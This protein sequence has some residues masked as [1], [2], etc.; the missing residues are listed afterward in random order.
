M[1]RM[2]E[3]ATLKAMEVANRLK[4]Q[5]VDIIAFNVG[6]PD[7]D[8]PTHIRRAAQKALDEGYTH[9]TP[10]AG[11]M[12]LREAVADKCKQ[13]NGIPCEAGNVI[14]TTCK[15][16]LFATILSMIEHGDEVIIPEPSWGSYVDMVNLAGGKAVHIGLK[17]DDKFRLRP[18]AV[19]EVITPKTKLIF[20]NSPTNPTGGIIQGKDMKAITELAED[21][22]LCILSDE[23]YEY[24][25]HEGKHV[26]PAS[27]PGIF[28]R[29]V[30][31]NGFSKAFSMTGW[32]MGY[33]VAPKEML[34]VIIK[35]Q[36]QAVT[37]APAFSQRACLTALRS[38]QS[39]K[40]LARMVKEFKKRRDVVVPGLDKIP[41]IKCPK[42]PGTFYAFP[43]F[44]RKMYDLTAAE[45]ATYLLETGHVSVT[46]GTAFGPSGEGCFRLSYSNSLKNIREGLKR[47][48]DALAKLRA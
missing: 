9:Y 32:R 38:K 11:F 16:A 1:G 31:V 27:F 33:L 3:S 26:S 6:E 22:D 39:K 25:I 29:T 43:S 15:F 13:E 18:E 21:H 23:V 14:V 19:A 44:D 12:D 10:S 4:A 7:F 48:E 47:I 41:G 28:D 45:M 46:A 2:G 34:K 40:A 8:T 35:M 17:G 42:S 30:T 37:C 20:L 36:Q 24:I 5:G